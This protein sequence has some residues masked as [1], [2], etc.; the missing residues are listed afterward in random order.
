MKRIMA[1]A[2]VLSM[3]LC[4]CGEK[5][6]ETVADKVTSEKTQTSTSVQS[7]STAAETTGSVTA[8]NGENNS[9]NGK[10]TEGGGTSSAADGDHSVSIPWFSPSVYEGRIDGVTKVRYLFD[11]VKSGCVMDLDAATTTKFE[12]EQ[13]KDTVVFKFEGSDAQSVM[14]MSMD[15]KGNPVG[16]IG[17]VTYVFVDPEI[18]ASNKAQSSD[19]PFVGVYL[20][21]SNNAALSVDRN[22]D[23]YT[24]YIHWAYSDTSVAEWTFTGE[25]NGRQ[26]LYYDNCIKNN[27]TYAADGSA[28]Y[29]QVYTNGTGY[30]SISEEGTK[31]GIVWSDDVE[32]AGS[33]AFFSMN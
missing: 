21:E 23:T 9:E 22:G 12:C 8:A 13:K 20:E 31:T 24:V 33:G 28:S 1:V 7:D 32:N 2:L 30:I 16:T 3:L 11:D 5:S 10:K 26:V 25:F 14:T 4:G 19:D 6:E 18:E 17:G 27:I 15:G 29:E